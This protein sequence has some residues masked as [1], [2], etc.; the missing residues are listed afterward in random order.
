MYFSNCD[1]IRE[2]QIERYG[3][4]GI[5]DPELL[6]SHVRVGTGGYGGNPEEDTTNF[7]TYPAAV[8]EIVTSI[9]QRDSGLFETNAL[10]ERYL[11]FEGAGAISTWSISMLGDPRPFDY[12]TI[13]D[14][15]LTI[16]YT[17]RAGGSVA[18]ART[19][20]NNWLKANSVR[21]FSMMHEFPSEWAAFK[22]AGTASATCGSS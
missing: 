7:M 22:S 14:V 13:S 12:D 10:D 9:A 20:A 21:V 2:N 17:A 5:R 8:Q 18:Q 3:G 15:V 1:F 4:P 19:N 6:K 16:Q 11:P